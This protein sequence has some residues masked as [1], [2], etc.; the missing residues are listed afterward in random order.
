MNRRSGATDAAA[1]T[2]GF[3]SANSSAT[4]TTA[5][6][7]KATPEIAMRVRREWA[8]LLLKLDQRRRRTNAGDAVRPVFHRSGTACRTWLR[9]C[10]VAFASMALNTGSNSPGELADHA[11]H[12]GRRGL[13]LER[14]VPLAGALSEQVLQLGR[15]GRA[16]TRGLRPWAGLPGWF[17]TARCSHGLQ[18]G[19]LMPPVAKPSHYLNKR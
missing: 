4:W 1:A 3:G 9:K 10:A 17:F 12:L 14:L 8:S 18:P 16:A 15:R 6:V 19:R 7:S 5:L 2:P 11:Q 13:L